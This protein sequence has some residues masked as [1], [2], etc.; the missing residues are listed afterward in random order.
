MA[1][2]VRSGGSHDPDRIERPRTTEAALRKWVLLAE[3]LRDVRDRMDATSWAE[4][5]TRLQFSMAEEVVED[6]SAV[7]D[8]LPCGECARNRRKRPN[9]ACPHMRE[10]R[11]RAIRVLA[12]KK[13]RHQGWQA[14]LIV[15]PPWRQPMAGHFVCDICG[16]ERE[17]PSYWNPHRNPRQDDET[18]RLCKS[19]WEEDR[20]E[21]A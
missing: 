18:R 6:L 17:L 21:P 12:G 3:R 2:R 11:Q 14:P 15:G 10:L 16:E 9:S 8:R 7:L 19:C 20:K 1:L 5:A 4:S 13:E